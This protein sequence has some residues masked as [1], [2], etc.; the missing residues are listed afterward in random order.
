MTKTEISFGLFDVEAKPDSTYTST[1]NQP[2]NNVMDLR[3]EDI[4]AAKYATMEPDYW[5]LDG[6]FQTFPNV[7]EN[8]YFGFISNI[9]SDENCNIDVK[10]EINF[11]KLHGS[12]GLSLTFDKAAGDYPTLINVTWY[13]TGGAL[14][15]SGKAYSFLKT[16]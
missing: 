7:P 3:K 15:H 6:S 2:F 4:Q 12:L 16:V 9:Q 14:L 8:E 5:L 10:L 11:T 13:G 1:D